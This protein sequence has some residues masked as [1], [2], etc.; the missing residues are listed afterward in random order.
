MGVL[1]CFLEAFSVHM[2]WLIMQVGPQIPGRAFGSVVEKFA[3][4]HLG[5]I[6]IWI[7]M[8]HL[9]APEEYLRWLS[10]EGQKTGLDIEGL[11]LGGPLSSSSPTCQSRVSQPLS[12]YWL[13]LSQILYSVEQKVHDVLKPTKNLRSAA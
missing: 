2:L 12:A 9:Q 10:L 13:C 7:M 6:D 3:P 5:K 8:G 1:C 4:A 11:A